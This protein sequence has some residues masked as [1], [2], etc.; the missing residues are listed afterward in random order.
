MRV[1]MCDVRVT[2]GDV[3]STRDGVVIIRKRSVY[4]TVWADALILVKFK[5]LAVS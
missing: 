3:H 1:D 4:D 2:F 5:R